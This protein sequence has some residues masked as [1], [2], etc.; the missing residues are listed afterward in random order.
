MDAKPEIV[1]VLGA[2]A[3]SGAGLPLAKELT[4][5]II[6]KI[7]SNHPELLPA[8]YFVCGAIAFGRG[9][10]GRNPHEPI[11][12]EEFLVACRDITQ[13]SEAPLYPFV[14]SW[15]ERIASLEQIP[16]PDAVNSNT[17]FDFL[18]EFSKRNLHEWLAVPDET[19]V[20]YLRSLKDFVNEG[21]RVSIFTLNYDECVEQALHDEFGSVNE[22]WV[23]GF[24]AQGW[25]PSLFED[26][27]TKIRLFKLHGSLDW[28]SDEE[29]GICSLRWPP[30]EGTEEIPEDYDSLIIYGTDAKMTPTDPFFTL[31]GEFR[32]ALARCC[33][34]GVVG[35]SFG[36][37]H[38]NEFILNAMES[39]SNLRCVIANY[40]QSLET[41]SHRLK[42]RIAEER[43]APVDGDV[44]MVFEGNRLLEA[45]KKACSDASEPPPF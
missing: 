31:L 44:K 27:D 7:E 2:G 21:F 29:F 32:D 42:R 1:L 8:V 28:V 45:M 26:T 30:A 11:N 4:T 43:F 15:H 10:N 23:N 25:E 9:C 16:I 40:D 17:P 18:V 19:H 41:L 6:T 13:R 36:D 37:E 38:I 20:K 33:A 39:R 14:S 35:Y 3:S 22:G 24:S 5:N 12:V 34:L